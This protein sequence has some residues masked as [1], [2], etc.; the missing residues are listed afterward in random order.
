MECS[1]II[2]DGESVTTDSYL[3][4]TLNITTVNELNEYARGT[5]EESTQKE[6]STWSGWVM[7]Y[8]NEEP[9]ISGFIENLQSHLREGYTFN[10]WCVDEACNEV[11][12]SSQVKQKM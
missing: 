5:H 12:N 3:I 2:K 8:V 10:L 7:L 9:P 1:V 11:Y 4:S 6:N